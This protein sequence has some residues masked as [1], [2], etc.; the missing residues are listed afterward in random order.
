[1][2]VEAK[3]SSPEIQM[4]EPALEDAV[5]EEEDVKDAWDVSDEEEEGK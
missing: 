1:M 3:E 2:E 4:E 5:E